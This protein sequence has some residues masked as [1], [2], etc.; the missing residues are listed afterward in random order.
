MSSATEPVYLIAFRNRIWFRLL[1]I[2]VLVY[3]I[4]FTVVLVGE[5][6]AWSDDPGAWA[7]LPTWTWGWIGVGLF[8]IAVVYFI[9]LLVRKEVP[10][11][12][13]I[14]KDSPGME[15]GH[16]QAISPSEPGPEDAT[17]Q[18]AS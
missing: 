18:G 5:Q 12:T 2:L 15:A 17:D 1:G 9:G 4:W 6:L 16:G 14:I 3:G 10:A 7:G 8:T 13:Y 11:Q